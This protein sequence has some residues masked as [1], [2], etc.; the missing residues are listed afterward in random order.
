MAKAISYI[1]FSSGKQQHGSSINR[2]VAMAKAWCE[3]REIPLSPLTYRDLGLSGYKGHN[4]ERGQLK[5]LIAECKKPGGLIQPGDY[6]IIEHYDRLS[7]LKPM[8]SYEIVKDIIREGIIIV[9]LSNGLEY[10]VDTLNNDQGR[11]FTLFGEL[12]QANQ[13]GANLERRSKGAHAKV[14]QTLQ[15]FETTG[16][17]I[18]HKCPSWLTWNPSKKIYEINNT[19]EIARE[20]WKLRAKPNHGATAIIEALEAKAFQCPKESG[21][22]CYIERVLHHTDEALGHKRIWGAPDK[23]GNQDD[24]GVADNYYP[25][26]ID[27]KTYDKAMANRERETFWRTGKQSKED[28]VNLF[29]G[30]LRCSVC[31]G[32]CKLS[33]SQKP[34]SPLRRYALCTGRRVEKTCKDGVSIRIDLVEDRVLKHITQEL[35]ASELLNDQQVVDSMAEASRVIT[36]TRKRMEKLQGQAEGLV[37]SLAD[38]DMIK[39]SRKLIQDQLNKISASLEEAENQYDDAKKEAKALQAALSGS[40]E[41]LDKVKKLFKSKKPADRKALRSAIASLVVKIILNPNQKVAIHFR[42]GL[43]RTVW[44]SRYIQ[45]GWGSY[46]LVDHEQLYSYDKDK[47]YRPWEEFR[48]HRPAELSREQDLEL[49]K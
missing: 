21:W 40:E 19:G 26:L 37:E 28:Y 45:R 38:P 12:Y 43:V 7:R 34:N 42:S 31:G 15:D 39:T 44:V 33:Q 2:Q 9:T 6:L 41:G 47:P 46:E 24:L 4:L 13:Y 22:K 48:E 3:Q 36:S 35:A 16:I 30:L 32:P 5:A 18:K 1:R 10:S 11:M 17:R 14:R 23:E 49:T 29:T 27:V 20:I 8:D 25:A